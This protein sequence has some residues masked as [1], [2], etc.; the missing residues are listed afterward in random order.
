VNKIPE[1]SCCNSL[2]RQ[3]H[4]QSQWYH[5]HDTTQHSEGSDFTPT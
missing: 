1:V 3:L 2:T 5:T 4:Y